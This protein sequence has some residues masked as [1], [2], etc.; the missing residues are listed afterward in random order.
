MVVNINFPIL[1]QKY[2]SKM[3]NE[4]QGTLLVLI[5]RIALHAEYIFSLLFVYIKLKRL[6]S[7]IDHLPKN[8]SNTDQA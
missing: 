8:I 1:R 6:R 7:N 5:Q 4:N 2:F 3:I